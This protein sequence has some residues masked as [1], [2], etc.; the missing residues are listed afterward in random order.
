MFHYIT[1]G[2]NDLRRSGT[3]YDAVM[4]SLGARRTVEREREISAFSAR[5][6]WSIDVVLESAA[7]ERFDVV[8]ALEIVELYE[9]ARRMSMTDSLT[10]LVNHRE[11][12]NAVRR[13]LER[14]RRYQHTVSLL[15]IDVDDF[16]KYINLWRENGGIGVLHRDNN[17][18]ATLAKLEEIYRPYLDK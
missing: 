11:F 9:N 1:L 14:A 6:Y 4:A 3:F 17:V 5:E 7:G 2:S 15:M 13:E 8:L 18:D 12:F 16:K 10:G